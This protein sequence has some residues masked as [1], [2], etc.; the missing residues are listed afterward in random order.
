MLWAAV[1]TTQQ[2][3]PKAMC[4]VYT[5]DHSVDKKQMISLAK[6][7]GRPIL[8]VGPYLLTRPRRNAST[9]R[10]THPP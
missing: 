8:S 5:G 9:S 3:W 4:V 1:R 7:I 6:V 10:S 2:T